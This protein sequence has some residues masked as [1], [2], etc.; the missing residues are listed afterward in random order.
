MHTYYMSYYSNG[1]LITLFCVMVL[2]DRKSILL[3]KGRRR[4]TG[5]NI[6]GSECTD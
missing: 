5:A 6:M 3:P 2:H 1:V 4:N